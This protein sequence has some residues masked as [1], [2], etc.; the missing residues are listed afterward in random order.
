MGKKKG[1]KGKKG[2]ATPENQNEARGSKHESY[3]SLSVSSLP[4]RPGE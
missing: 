3:V 4:V 2:D 1:K